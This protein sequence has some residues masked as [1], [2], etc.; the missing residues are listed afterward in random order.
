MI[1]SSKL[2]LAKPKISK[3]L[4]VIGKTTSVRWF[5]VFF[6]T[7]SSPLKQSRTDCEGLDILAVNCVTIATFS[8]PFSNK[9]TQFALPIAA[10]II[11]Y[12]MILYVHFYLN[13][14][15]FYC[16]K[17]SNNYFSIKYGNLF[18][19]LGKITFRIS[20]QPEIFLRISVRP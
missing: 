15:G 2:L 14:T 8:V 10:F 18:C 3:I 11:T 17:N 19:W 7:L 20:C 9:S 5:K 1:E 4:S 16:R 6:E 12:S 13:I